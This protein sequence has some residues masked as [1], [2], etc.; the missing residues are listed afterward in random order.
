MAKL[1]GVEKVEFY[2]RLLEDAA[3]DG[4]SVMKVARKHGVSFVTLYRWR[5]HFGARLVA[6]PVVPPP[7]LLPVELVGSPPNQAPVISV[8]SIGG[9][10]LEGGFLLK[11][12]SGHEVRVPSGF[13]GNELRALVAALETSPCS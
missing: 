4:N 13:N 3:Q 11:L 8:L 10:P 1:N 7:D 2:R 5:K 12:R 9:A 6:P